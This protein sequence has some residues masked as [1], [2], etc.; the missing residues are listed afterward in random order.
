M[1]H[2]FIL[3][4]G[5]HRIGCGDSLGHGGSLGCGHSLG[6][7]GSLGRGDNLIGGDSLGRGD[8]L[9]RGDFLISGDSLGHGD[10]LIS[11]DSLI[12]AV[13]TGCADRTRSVETTGRDMIGH[14]K[15]SF[16]PILTEREAFLFIF[17]FRFSTSS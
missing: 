15:P 8:S 5:S 16:W 11:G 7:G 13:R 10:S 1:W 6:R 3:Y 17:F 14:T 12:G 4:E 9:V 2:L